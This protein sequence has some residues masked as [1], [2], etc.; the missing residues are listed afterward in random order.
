MK[1]KTD[2]SKLNNL[3]RN[4]KMILKMMH[5]VKQMLKETYKPIVPH[6]RAGDALDV[7]IK[8]LNKGKEVERKISGVCLR[9]ASSTFL[10]RNKGANGDM[11]YNFSFF[12]PNRVEITKCGK[13]RRG[14]IYYWRELYGKKAKIRADFKRNIKCAELNEKAKRYCTI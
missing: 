8:V 4:M 10:I 1:R 11:E 2:H 13:V 3:E 5:N 9:V 14:R 12:M 6:F 7:Y